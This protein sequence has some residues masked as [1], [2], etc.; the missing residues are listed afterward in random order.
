MQPGFPYFIVGIITA[1]SSFLLARQQAFSSRP[2]HI[3]IRTYV[4][5]VCY[6]ADDRDSSGHLNS[7]QL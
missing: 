4:L 7:T 6:A 2:S 3:S 5:T 1:M